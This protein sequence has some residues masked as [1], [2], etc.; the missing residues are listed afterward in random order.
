[1]F[2]RRTG[3]H[4]AESDDGRLDDFEE[5]EDV[6]APAPGDRPEGP[7]D[8]EEPAPEMDRVDLGA[9]RVPVGPDLEVQVNL[10]GEQIVAATVVQGRNALQ[11][12]ALAAPKTLEIW[13]DIR[14]EV[15]RELQGA[16][17]SAEEVEGEFGTELRAH[18]L[19]EAQG[20]G[21]EGKGAVAQRARFVGVDGPRWLLRGVFTGPAADDPGS[22]RRLE[23]VFRAI[24][25]VRGD[26]PAPPREL[27]ELQLP[28]EM[29]RPADAPDH[30]DGGL[31]LD[32][33]RRG[34]E[35]TEIR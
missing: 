1:M 21:G 4:R 9:L 5:D 19:A 8:V 25:V 31:E 29:R 28:P 13:D 27:L 26:A 12:Q 33:F 6:A 16:G 10:A 7:W 15:V 18:V 14:R 23:Q 30:D 17:G 2:R 32:P 24:V 35:I 20:Q 34:P 22:A 11:V 3:R